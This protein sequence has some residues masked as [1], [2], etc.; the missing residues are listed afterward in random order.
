[1]TSNA[2]LQSIAAAVPPQV[3]TQSELYTIFEQS[4]ARHR[5]KER[6]QNLMRK[7]LRSPNGIE[8]RHLAL[9]PLEDIFD[10]NAEELNQAFE[11]YAS[12][13]SHQALE[14]ALSRA[15]LHPPDIDA[16]FVCTCTGY[17]CPGISSHVAEAAGLR[18]DA[19]LHDLVGMG[20]GAAIPTLR[21][22][23]AFARA[24]P[25]AR[26]AII[27]VEICSAAFYLDDDPGVLISDCLFGDGGACIIL[28]D[29]PPPD[30]PAWV[31][32][33]FDTEHCPADRELLRFRNKGGKLRNQLHKTIPTVA[34]QAVRALWDRCPAK[35]TEGTVYRLAHPGGRDV[36]DALC[37]AF[38]GDAF[39]ESRWILKHGGNL[40]SPSILFA[41]ASFLSHTPFKERVE[42]PENWAHDS[43]APAS[44]DTTDSLWLTS[45]GAGFSAHS[46]RMIKGQAVAI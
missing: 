26:V 21:A 39:A 40:S 32:A 7:I 34:A 44:A 23:S 17:L 43:P 46:C 45:F 6:S 35:S 3:Y 28:A 5:L 9:E 11:K 29:T 10:L 30:A 24:E 41:L 12:R 25:G 14:K 8:T 37:S 4:Q 1:M 42:L 16:L 27:A 20:C 33:D 2:Y 19:Y 31:L 38:A 13:L 36:V 18:S 15:G 22:A